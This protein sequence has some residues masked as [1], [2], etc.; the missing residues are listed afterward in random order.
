[1]FQDIC[2]Y[3]RVVGYEVLTAV[4]TI[5]L[6]F[7]HIMP[8]SPLKVN[9]RYFPSIFSVK[10]ETKQETSM[11]QTSCWFIAWLVF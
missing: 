10:E 11:Q 1:M 9:R 8:H 6:I 5:S 4:V 3:M 2:F 7:W